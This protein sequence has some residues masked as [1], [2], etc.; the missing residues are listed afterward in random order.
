MHGVERANA[1]TKREVLTIL[2]GGTI[3]CLESAELS[4]RDGLL[5]SVRSSRADG[6]TGSHIWAGGSKMPESRLAK[7]RRSLMFCWSAG[8]VR[9]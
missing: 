3:V 8:S 9:L 7:R 6:S 2:E 1:Q 5:N 4:W